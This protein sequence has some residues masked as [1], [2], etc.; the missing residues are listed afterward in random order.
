[1]A[2]KEEQGR[3]DKPE[4]VQEQGQDPTPV[5]N[6]RAWDRAKAKEKL[7]P[8]GAEREQDP[9]LTVGRADPWGKV[10]GRGDR[11]GKTDRE[12]LF[13]ARR[14][15]G[16]STSRISRKDDRP[17]RRESH[18]R[19]DEVLRQA[20][21]LAW[22]VEKEAAPFVLKGLLLRNDELDRVRVLGMDKVP[23]RTPGRG[24]V[25][26]QGGG[27][28]RNAVPMVPA[29]SA[30]KGPTVVL[31]GLVPA[32]AVVVVL[33]VRNADPEGVVEALARNV[34]RA[35]T[36]VPQD[37]VIAQAVVQVRNADLEAEEGALARIATRER[38]VAHLD[39]REDQDRREVEVAGPS[40]A[41]RKSSLGRGGSSG[42]TAEHASFARPPRSRSPNRI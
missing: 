23:I 3:V 8:S 1:V 28:D 18:P 4:V 38:T 16:S 21:D 25:T 9:V 26:A 24:L 20:L 35:R 6:G 17:D 39:G 36:Q 40:E 27:L 34:G 2:R 29:R 5:H 11:P 12:A 13:I 32:Q 7:A 22:E 41:P 14:P 15:A 37:L 31:K 33:V 19:S 30:V 10:R 42:L